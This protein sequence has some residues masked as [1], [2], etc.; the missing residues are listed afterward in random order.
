[1][2]KSS[3]LVR[4]SRWILIALFIYLMSYWVRYTMEVLPDSLTVVLLFY[5]GMFFFLF[6][7]VIFKRIFK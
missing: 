4:L 6:I 5:G 2:K 1:M 7:A 3:W